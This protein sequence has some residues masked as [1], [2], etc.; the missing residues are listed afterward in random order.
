MWWAKGGNG[1]TTDLSKAETYTRENA[2]RLHDCRPTD[3][4]WPKSYIDGKTRPAVDMQY[5]RR[6]D[7]IHGSGI[8]LAE[9]KRELKESIRCS[10]CGAFITQN[11]VFFGCPKCGASNAP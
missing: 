10:H 2:Q 3:I 11:Q 4:P 8:V 6:D 5:I 1:Y 9:P 7:A